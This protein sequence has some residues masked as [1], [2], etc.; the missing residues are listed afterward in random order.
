MTVNLS[1]PPSPVTTVPAQLSQAWAA[2]SPGP[3][4]SFATP[5]NSSAG[6]PRRLSMTMPAR[7]WARQ[8]LSQGVRAAMARTLQPM[9]AAAAACSSEDLEKF[10]QR[11]L[12][13]LSQPELKALL[14]RLEADYKKKFGK[15]VAVRA[16]PAAEGVKFGYA[17]DLSRC[18]GCRRCVHACVGEN[19]QS[20]PNPEGK[21]NNPIQWIKV[22]EM[23]KEKGKSQ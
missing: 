7:A 20:R 14:I 19:N 16:T 2:M 1:Y 8:A 12:R 13:E 9:A 6:M 15:D 23:E 22:L 4:F 21:H 17:L 3:D 11:R 5:K 18:I 10:T